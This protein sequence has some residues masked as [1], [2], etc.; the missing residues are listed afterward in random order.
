MT[1]HPLTSPLTGPIVVTGATGQL[2][3]LVLAS[4]LKQVPAAQLV[5]A[6]RSPEK[7]QDLAAQGIQV[8]K[9]DYDRPDTLV[10][11]FRG[12]GK[13]LLISSN[14]IGQ[15]FA[16]HRAAVDAARKAGV[17]LLAYTSLLRAD[18]SPLPLALEHRETEAYLKASGLPFVLLRN[19]WYTENYAASIPSALQ[20]GAFL[21]SA[22]EGKIASAA[23]ADYA[24]AAAAVLLRDGQAG[25]VHELAGDTA[26]TLRELTA[27]L[28]RQSGKAVA[29]QNLP[30]AEFKAILLG[31]GLPEAI[32]SLL[33][34]S[35]T[36]AAKGGLFD[37]SRTL[38]RLIGRPTTPMA[39]T[40][41]AALRG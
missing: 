16:Q 35:D 38:R 27:E 2:G 3:R 15:R 6:V 4:L 13:V 25:Q 19:G 40:V 18:T 17:P 37:D 12:A 41:G 30:E 33:A 7:A 29:Y 26:Y 23:R 32:A 8:R 36:G 24:E 34:E 22:G 20:H 9:A 10:E 28:S 21:G 31:A 14:E 39:D 1:P 5:A 11:A